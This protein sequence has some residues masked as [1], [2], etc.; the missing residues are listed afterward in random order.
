MT[1]DPRPDV[2][3]PA[4][5]PDATASG[6]AE[7]PA[8]GTSRPPR[9][10]RQLFGGAAILILIVAA[11]LWSARDHPGARQS[12][13]AAAPPRATAVDPGPAPG[14][15]AP[16]AP[17]GPTGSGA[18]GSAPSASAVATPSPATDTP[19]P[20]PAT[21]TPEALGGE[22]A[23]NLA[24]HRPAAASS[25]DGPSR[26]SGK[27]VDGDVQTGW[28]SASTDS[29]WLVVD[30]GSAQKISQIRISWG[31]AFAKKYEIEVS[32]NGKKWKSVFKTNSGR[33]GNVTVHF[34]EKNARY[35]LINGIKPDSRDG[36]SVLELDVR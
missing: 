26:G 2:P 11:L 25:S 35:V 27:A 21:T 36:Y 23:G 22:A 5:T 9:M 3:L 33:G 12:A 8:G 31:E 32:K 1:A 28:S 7:S 6:V 18:L 17:A 16:G 4:A 10:S 29:Q 34:D 20:A 14:A 13:A 30:L 15:P 24:L 19:E